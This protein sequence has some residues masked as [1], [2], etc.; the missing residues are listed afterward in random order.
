MTM[1]LTVLLLIIL[2]PI[3]GWSQNAW[4]NIYS[5]SAWDERDQWQ[6]LEVI[7]AKLGLKLGD[8]VAD[9]GCHEGY[10]TFKLA[11]KVGTTGEVFAVDVDQSKLQMQR[12]VTFQLLKV[13]T[14]IQSSR[15]I[16]LTLC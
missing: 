16:L 12:S 10:M 15:S 3:S 7:I 11:S 9:I 6:K 8:Q 1:R 4:K 13:I 2:L 5:E 14:M